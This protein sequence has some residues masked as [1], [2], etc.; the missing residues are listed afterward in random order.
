MKKQIKLIVTDFDGT[1]VDFEN[2]PYYSSWDALGML[3]S[4]E[5]KKKW[6]KIREK[7][8]SLIS[9]TNSL[10][11]KKALDLEFFNEDLDLLKGESKKYFEESIFPLNYSKGAKDFFLEMRH[12][13]KITGILSSGIDFIIKRA[14]KELKMNFSFCSSIYE[15]KGFFNGKGKNLGLFEKEKYLL[16]ICKNYN[17]SLEEA[18][19]FGDHFNC[20][21]CIKLAGLGIAVNPKIEEIKEVS[22]YVIKDFRGALDL[23]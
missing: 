9:K 23:I 3:L 1:L 16:D 15:T 4:Q 8:F 11:E 22:D 2:E 14:Q 10:D 20:V 18:C 7:Y 19:Y 6:I 5:K 12:Q 17:V 21:P 13:G